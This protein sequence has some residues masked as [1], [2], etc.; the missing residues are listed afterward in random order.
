MPKAVSDILDVRIIQIIDGE[1][2]VMDGLVV[3]IVAEETLAPYGADT[4]ADWVNAVPHDPPAVS[5]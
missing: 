2:V 4:P 5:E 3:P 1:P